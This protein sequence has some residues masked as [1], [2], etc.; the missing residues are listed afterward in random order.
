[1]QDVHYKSPEQAQK[2]IVKY[3]ELYYTAKVMHSSLEY[4]SPSQFTAKQLINNPRRFLR[5]LI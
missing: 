3:I 4:F 1:M 2:E 5:R